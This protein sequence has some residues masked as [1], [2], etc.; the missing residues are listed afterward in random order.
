MGKTFKDKI[1]ASKKNKTSKYFD[2]DEYETKKKDF[3]KKTS[4]IKNK[5]SPIIDDEVEDEE[6]D[7]KEEH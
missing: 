1:K 4:K 2:Y 3:V 7:N 6:W 5:Q